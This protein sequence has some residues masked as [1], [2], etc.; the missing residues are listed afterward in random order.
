MYTVSLFLISHLAELVCCSILAFQLTW[1]LILLDPCFTT[2][3]QPTII[4][5]FYARSIGGDISHDGD[6]QIFEGNR[7]DRKGFLYKNFVMS[8]IVSIK[9]IPLKRLE[10]FF[11]NIRCSTLACS[12]FAYVLKFMLILVTRKK[13]FFVESWFFQAFRGGTL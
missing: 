2:K 9:L 3:Q 4:C 1:L 8:A 7:Y 10:F 12:K 13:N 6:F 11:T 5:T